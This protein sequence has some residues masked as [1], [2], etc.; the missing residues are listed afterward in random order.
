VRAGW[1]VRAPGLPAV[2]QTADITW[3]PSTAQNLAKLTVPVPAGFRQVPFGTAVTPI[4][5]QI[6]GS[7]VPAFK[8]RPAQFPSD[9]DR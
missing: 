4:L 2:Q 5:R 1:N 6:L 8:T 3:L 9:D 7:P